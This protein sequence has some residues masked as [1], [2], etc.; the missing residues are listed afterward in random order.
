MVQINTKL[1]DELTNSYKSDRQRLGEVIVTLWGVWCCSLL[2]IC[3]V[4]LFREKILEK[5]REEKWK[6]MEALRLEREGEAGRR[7]EGEAK[8]PIKPNPE[9]CQEGG[10][11]SSNFEEGEDAKEP[12]PSPEAS[13]DTSNNVSPNN[14]SPNV[15][16]SDTWFSATL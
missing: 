8:S 15:T 2:V 10:A 12:G 16:E 6:K 7:T 5:E 4:Y 14:V 9:L 11:D 1:F 3:C 13:K